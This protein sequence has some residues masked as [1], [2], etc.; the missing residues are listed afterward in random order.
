MHH[1]PPL[2]P[3]SSSDVEVVTVATIARPARAIVRDELSAEELA[4]FLLDHRLSWVAVADK[5]KKIV[6]FA[7]MTDLAGAPAGARVRDMMRPFTFVLDERLSIAR[8]AAV[9]AARGVHRLL[10]VSAEGEAVGLVHALDVLRWFARRHGV[11]VADETKQ[12]WR[13][14]CDEQ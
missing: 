2:P 4:S 1:L 3:T 5:Q 14:L 8:V 12:S 11:H 10:L 9:M 13:R 7:S 6:G